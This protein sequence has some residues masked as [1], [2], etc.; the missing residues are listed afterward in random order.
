MLVRVVFNARGALLTP[1]C[2]GQIAWAAADVQ[3]SASL[4]LAFP[5]AVRALHASATAAAAVWDDGEADAGERGDAAVRLCVPPA[6]LLLAELRRR[7]Y[8]RRA[9]AVAAWALAHG[10]FADDADDA[11]D[12]ALNAAPALGQPACAAVAGAGD[13]GSSGGGGSGGDEV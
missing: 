11:D 13:G 4:I 3:R 10:D 1:T 7:A 6:P 9:H 2:G 5:S 12:D 8:A